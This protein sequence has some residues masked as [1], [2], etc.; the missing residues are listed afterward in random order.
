M[1]YQEAMARLES[2]LQRVDN[3]DLGIDE[4]AASVQEASEL[5]KTCRRILMQTEKQVQAALDSLDTDF[6]MEE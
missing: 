6:K 2:I 3:M 4:L 5:L 1:K